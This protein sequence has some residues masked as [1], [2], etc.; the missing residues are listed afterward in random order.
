MVNTI[1]C[2]KVNTIR[3]NMKDIPSTYRNNN[4]A[5]SGNL[6]KYLYPNKMGRNY[7]NTNWYNIHHNIR[8]QNKG[9]E[10]FLILQNRSNHNNRRIHIH[11]PRHRN[12][13]NWKH[14]HSRPH[15]NILPDN[16][17]HLPP[18]DSIHLRSNIHYLLLRYNYLPANPVLEA[19]LIELP[20]QALLPARS[21]SP[22]KPV[23]HLEYNK[24]HRR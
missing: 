5:T 13:N 10:T 17:E 22:Q 24:Y 4:L 2:N 23:H 7:T 19:F 21:L 18:I 1:H 9:Y 6:N 14:K 12:N 15:H 20:D 3:N 16:P 11:L 8:N